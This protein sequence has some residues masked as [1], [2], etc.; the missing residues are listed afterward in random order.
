MLR[1]HSI[2]LLVS[3][4][5]AVASA[6]PQARGPA[7][8]ERTRFLTLVHKL[9]QSPLDLGLR[10]ERTWAIGWALRRRGA[11]VP[12]C[13]NPFS[14]YYAEPKYTYDEEI[15]TQITL[16]N[17][18]FGIEHPSQSGDLSA[19]AMA[20]IESVLKAYGSILK[21]EPLARSIA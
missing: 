21:S 3:L 7:Q 13:R 9:E 11:H 12:V 16:S 14:G 20:S 10:R 4:F 5:I 19:E 18:A 17:A 1:S 6:H 8:D 15:V 2:V